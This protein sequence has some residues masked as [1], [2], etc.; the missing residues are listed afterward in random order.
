MTTTAII[1]LV[2]F[3]TGASVVQRVSGFGFGIFI[4]T[5][6]PHIMPS[7]GEATMLSGILSALQSLY[8]LTSVY[9]QINW[10]HVLPILLTFIVVSFFAVQY[11]SMAADTHLKHLLGVIL[12]VMSCYFLVISEKI[13][14]KPTL[15]IQI[16]MGSLSGIMGGL[17]AMQGPP[18][19]LYFVASESDKVRY[20]A[21][22]QAYFFIGNVV[23][24][25]YRAQ[26]GFLTPTVGWCCLYAFAGI[27]VGTQIGRLLF[28]KLPLQILRKIIYAY[29]AVGGV[30]ALLA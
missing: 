29:M 26:S 12:I 7:Y 4:M 6:L 21:A 27:I 13:H 20:L 18:A 17:F 22:T 10:R 16:S 24:T 9:R 25:G 11:V 19:V 30:V 23:M 15:P 14:L 8:V 5:V 3:C 1:L 28:N 2:L